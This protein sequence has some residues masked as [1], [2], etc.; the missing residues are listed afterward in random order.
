MK[1]QH[2]NLT[3]NVEPTCTLPALGPCHGCNTVSSGETPCL[4]PV[5]TAPM[6]A[7][8]ACLPR[9]KASFAVTIARRQRNFPP[10]MRHARAA[11]L[12]ANRM[13]R[14]NCNRMVE[15]LRGYH[16]HIKLVRLHDVGFANALKHSRPTDR[17]TRFMRRC[18]SRACSSS[19]M[20]AT[21]PT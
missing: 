10:P 21:H 3:R 1:S 7:A 2:N 17:T 18:G 6:P 8:N 12:P 20:T 13:Q 14:L 4:K 9:S 16:E 5:T 19:G 15:Q 11:I